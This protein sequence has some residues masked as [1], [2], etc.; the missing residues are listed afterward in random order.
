MKVV[1]LGSNKEEVQAL[2]MYFLRNYAPKEGLELRY[3][4]NSKLE[5]Y[6]NNT[7]DLYVVRMAQENIK[8]CRFN[9][10][11]Y[12]D[13]IKE[14]LVNNIIYPMCLG[15]DEPIK[16]KLDWNLEIK[17][18]ETERNSMNNKS[19]A[20]LIEL[21]SMT[22]RDTVDMM[23]S[24]DYKERFKAE[25]YQLSLRLKGLSNMLTKYKEGTLNFKPI[26][27]YELLAEQAYHMREYLKILEERARLEDIEL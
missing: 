1:F 13:T 8:A 16:L 18:D 24:E 7:K 15:K 21:N 6:N 19:K 9:K 17:F 27:S 2:N 10:I 12:M 14:D 20:M 5:Y 3:L 25:Y 23:N 4:S 22:L 11:Y 26:C